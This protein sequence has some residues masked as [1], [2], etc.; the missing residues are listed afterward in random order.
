MKG[1]V[2][3]ACMIS[4]ILVLTG[5]GH[6]QAEEDAKDVQEVIPYQLQYE[7]PDGYNQYYTKKPPVQIIHRD[8]SGITQYEFVSAGGTKRS[9]KL[10]LNEGEE[11]R[12]VQIT[13]R[14]MEEGTNTLNVWMEIPQIPKEE[15]DVP[16]ESEIE[17]EEPDADST[18][19]NMLGPV[20]MQEQTVTFLIDTKPPSAVQFSYGHQLTGQTLLSH[21][22]VAVTM[23]ASDDG[24]GVKRIVYTAGQGQEQYLEGNNGS[25]VIPVGF[26]GSIRAYS[27]DGAGNKS[28]VSE[29]VRIVSE[30]TLPEITLTAPKGFGVWYSQDIPVQVTVEE[31]GL[32]SGLQMIRCFINGAL[33]GQAEPDGKKSYKTE[34]SVSTQ[35]IGGGGIAVTVE[36]IDKAGNVATH[37]EFLFL[38]KQAPVTRIEGIDNHTIT[39]QSAKVV[40]IIEE[41]NEIQESVACVEWTNL[42]GEIEEL[43]KSEWERTENGQKASVELKEDGIY[44]LILL[45]SDKAGHHSRTITQVIIDKENP[46]I[47]YVDQM[48]GTYVRHFQWNYKK[49]EMIQD[50]TSFTYDMQL[51][52]RLYYPGEYVSAEGVHVLSVSAQDA[53]GN[54]SRAE[55]EFTVDHTA[56]KILFGDVENQKR[57]KETTLTITLENAEDV[58]KEIIINGEKQRINKES[59]VFQFPFQEEGRYEVV[60]KA[61]DLAQNETVDGITFYIAERE[62]LV[63]KVV[64]PISKLFRKQTDVNMGGQD[65]ER[66]K[67]WWLLIVAAVGIAVVKISR[68]REDAG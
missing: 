65:E 29:S 30:Q 8:P 57:Y 50:F 12:T 60:V 19:E 68:K 44:R 27:V 16:E 31:P 55:A 1:K 45:A 41:E 36:A 22:S 6:L 32:S 63:Q 14:E 20:K 26:D 66:V 13:P 21:E 46:V 53:A 23:T 25:M 5:A 47:R 38:D 18:Q 10:Q 2:K 15:T 40:F 7:Q 34:L 67:P 58:V 59:Q 35:F 52:G 3:K 64:K 48:R 28:P 37:S 4:M 54:C 9:G 17:E 39:S 56:P 11:E 49:E 42:E 51:D 61:V 62:A 33:A 24:A 43:P